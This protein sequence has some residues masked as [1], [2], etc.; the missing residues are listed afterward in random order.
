MN[1]IEEKF[2]TKYAPTL[3]K[4]Q[5]SFWEILNSESSE[6]SYPS[7]GHSSLA[8]IEDLSFWFRHRNKVISSLVKEFSP[9]GPILD[10]GGGNGYV[11]LGL[12][13]NEFS[14][15][16]IEPGKNGAEVAKER[17]LEVINSEFN[18]DLFEKESISAI[19]LFD[20]VEHIED[21]VNFLKM[22][23]KNLKP[24]GFL[25]ITVPAYQSLW[26]DDDVFA[27]HYRRYNRKTL[28]KLL[29]DSGFEVMR[30]TMFFSLLIA[31]I[32]FLRTIP[33]FF[34]KKVKVDNVVTDH[35]S[36]SLIGKIAEF[37]FSFE[38]KL[39][40]RGFKIPFGASIVVVARKY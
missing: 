32:F 33:S 23:K 10:V 34:G 25:Y 27:G 1:N 26:S 7:S 2:I 40:S 18:S 3:R 28:S 6:V 21:D 39:I 38:N 37:I 36:Q 24:G 31:P 12:K 20:V 35:K 4:N 5:K 9:S 13:K 30:M 19:G 29:K 17:G 16:V 8:E 14:T 11:S 15:I 22:C